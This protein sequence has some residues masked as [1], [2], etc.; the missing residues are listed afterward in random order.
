MSTCTLNG[1]AGTQELSAVKMLAIL[2]KFN[3]VFCNIMYHEKLQEFIR[4]FVTGASCWM[5]KKEQDPYSFNSEDPSHNVHPSKDEQD[6]I[7]KK[8]FTERRSQAN[9]KIMK[10]RRKLSPSSG[11]DR[12]PLTTI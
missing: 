11:N 7:E 12:T 4:I 3:N 9:R 5:K 6:K 10:G 1:K 8:V 2:R